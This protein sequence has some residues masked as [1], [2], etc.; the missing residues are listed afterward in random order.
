MSLIPK[1][2][3]QHAII[4]DKCP[5]D[6]RNAGVSLIIDKNQF[7]SMINQC[8]Q[9]GGLGALALWSFLMSNNHNYKID[10]S[11]QY[12]MDCTGYSRSAASKAMDFLKDNGYIIEEK[13]NMFKVYSWPYGT[14]SFAQ[15]SFDELIKLDKKD[16]EEF[17]Y[18]IQDKLTWDNLSEDVQKFYEFYQKF[19]EE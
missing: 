15:M 2:P 11:P 8:R 1:Y 16:M 10:Y 13:P 7:Y 5:E 19:Y 4:V 14:Q 18:Q 3:N 9:E 17:Y 12:F 6:R